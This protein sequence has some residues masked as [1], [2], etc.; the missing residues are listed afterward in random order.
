MPFSST[1][2]SLCHSQED[3]VFNSA[4]TARHRV[5]V[6]Y[7][8]GLLQTGWYQGQVSKIGFLADFIAGDEVWSLSTVLATIE[9]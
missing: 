2:S 3:R 4:D 1:S 9:A 6:R 7:S 8:V 5:L